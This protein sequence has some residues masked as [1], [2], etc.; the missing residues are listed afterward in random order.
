[1][2]RKLSNRSLTNNMRPQRRG[3]LFSGT[4]IIQFN[5]CSR[6]TYCFAAEK[7]VLALS[8]T[9]I[10]RLWLSWHATTAAR[11]RTDIVNEFPVAVIHSVYGCFGG[12][13]LQ[14]KHISIHSTFILRSN[15]PGHNYYIVSCLTTCGV[16]TMYSKLPQPTQ[17]KKNQARSYFLHANAKKNKKIIVGDERQNLFRSNDSIWARCHFKN[18]YLEIASNGQKCSTVLLIG[19]ENYLFIYLMGFA[20]IHARNHNGIRSFISTAKE[21]FFGCAFLFP[22][23]KMSHA[24]ESGEWKWGAWHIFR[25]IR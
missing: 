7:M 18:K 2:Y 14:S 19:A 8:K 11:T 15:V 9:V 16:D 22:I 20:A 6:S 4:K 3:E 24:T 21:K 23:H 5:W 1:M 25:I 13:V 12:L 10:L 17:I